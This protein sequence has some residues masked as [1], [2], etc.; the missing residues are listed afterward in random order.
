MDLIYTVTGIDNE[1]KYNQSG[2]QCLG[3]FRTETDA[4]KAVKQNKSDLSELG[5]HGFIV[6]ELFKPGIYPLASKEIWFQWDKE[7]RRY[8]ELRKKPREEIGLFNY[9]MG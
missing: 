1:N 7:K 2:R 3:W 8:I 4:K 6:I 5:T 9:G